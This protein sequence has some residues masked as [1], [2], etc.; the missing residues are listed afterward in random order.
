M[1]EAQVESTGMVTFR[2]G[3]EDFEVLEQT[4]RAKPDTLLCTLLDD[5]EQQKPTSKP[6]C[7]E[8]DKQRF[9]YI[10]DW[11]RY[12]SIR[13]PTTI[14]VEEMRRECA[15][16]QLPD[17]VKISQEIG[18]NLLPLASE[19]F[20]Q[21][22]ISAEKEY[23]KASASAVAAHLFRSALFS[24]RWDGPSSV[25]VHGLDPSKCVMSPSI[26][27]ITEAAEL[28]GAR[29]GFS[30]QVDRT[31]SCSTCGM[32][33]QLTKKRAWHCQKCQYGCA[34]SFSYSCDVKPQKKAARLEV[35]T[36]HDE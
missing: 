18:L 13:I 21:C 4:V 23:Q 11:Y 9:R 6:I 3:G 19:A 31:A 16:F 32:S 14:A 25:S 30:C 7:V 1:D 26:E 33:A 34:V 17:D 12:G 2:V 5:P 29:H 27:M 10:L 8:G 35:S 20:E 22:K 24:R 28:L 36:S 15:F